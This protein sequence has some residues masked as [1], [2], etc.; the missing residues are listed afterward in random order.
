MGGKE[1]QRYESFSK[2]TRLVCCMKGQVSKALRWCQGIVL[3]LHLAYFHRWAGGNKQGCIFSS[4]AVLLHCSATCFE[5]LLTVCVWP[6]CR[7]WPWTFVLLTIR[8]WFGSTCAAL[9]ITGVM[10]WREQSS[11]S[12]DEAYLEAQRWIEVSKMLFKKLKYQ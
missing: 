4:E 11:L 9:I 8:T 1:S 2:Q 5:E 12:C 3:V 6:G 10:E 7:L